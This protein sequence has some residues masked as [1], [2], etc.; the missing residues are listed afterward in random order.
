MYVSNS[1]LEGNKDID[2]YSLLLMNVYSKERQEV[3]KMLLMLSPT[4]IL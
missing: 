3:C 4:M 2:I 1:T